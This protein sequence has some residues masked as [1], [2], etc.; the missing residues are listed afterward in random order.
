MIKRF[1]I[2]MPFILITGCASVKTE[3]YVKTDPA[4]GAQ[5]E[6]GTRETKTSFSE[7]LFDE[8]KVKDIAW[9]KNGWY[10]RLTVQLTGSDNYLPN[11]T[12]EG[13]KVNSGHIT[14]TEK[15]KQ[16]MEGCIK[17]MNTGIS[18]DASG[19]GI[20]IKEN[21]ENGKKEN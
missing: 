15:S 2:L 20:N 10:F 16:N 4:T 7:M 5:I 1:L 14:L 8:M 11:F 12:F 21:Q 3:D 18:L 13:G 17:A 19:K 6:K 9:W